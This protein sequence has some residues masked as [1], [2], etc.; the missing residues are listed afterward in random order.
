MRE[1][2]AKRILVLITTAYSSGREM[3]KGIGR[4]CRS[5][6]D[7][8][9]TL[10]PGE[11]ISKS[12]LEQL[13]TTNRYDGIIDDE[14][15]LIPLAR[16]LV[17]ADTPVVVTGSPREKS[18]PIPS[19]TT[20]VELGNGNVG[21]LV[22]E[23][24]IELGNFSSFAFISE[25]TSATWVKN[26]RDGFIRHLKTRGLPV[27]TYTHVNDNDALSRF[28][29]S[30]SKPA[31]V[32]CAW[33][34]LAVSVL[35]ACRQTKIQVP[36]QVSV[37]SVDNDETLC[38]FT[39]PAIS[40][41]ELPHEALGYKAAETLHRILR[42]KKR[43]FCNRIQ[44]TDKPRIFERESSA[45]TVP[46]TIL[47]RRALAMV[48]ENL[49]SKIR[50]GDI[51]GALGVSRQLLELRFREIR[52]ETLKDI[53]INSKLNRVRQLLRDTEHSIEEVSRSCGYGTSSHLK[54]FFR[55]RFGMTM[56]AYRR[57]S[58]CPAQSR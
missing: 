11:R 53:I 39:S 47:I 43:T 51:A 5:I 16:L 33:D 6:D 34:R 28:L 35:N 10:I 22:A 50:V 37:I 8:D 57:Q 58:R 1:K 56:S 36:R 7:W 40:S 46:A 48:E 2:K 14:G 42:R 26:R 52:G 3:L 9:V 15:H 44:L 32:M 49:S 54:A 41:V 17:G 18:G 27:F 21:T 12:T 29:S 25:N 30:L 24:F 23:Q 4:F 45:P 38:E 55:K 31:A 13:V 19:R 20:F